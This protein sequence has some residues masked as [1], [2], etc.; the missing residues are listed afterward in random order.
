MINKIK[1]SG[2]TSEYARKKKEKKK[3]KHANDYNK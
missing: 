2:F 3:K 1:I